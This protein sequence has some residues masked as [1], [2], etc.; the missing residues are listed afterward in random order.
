MA[1]E[2][3]KTPASGTADHR[4]RSCW[5]LRRKLA[6][7][8]IESE[9]MV[10]VALSSGI[11]VSAEDIAVVRRARHA[12][13][14]FSGTDDL[15]IALYDTATRLSRL[16]NYPNA[17]V[18]SDLR[19]AD[20]LLSY[21]ARA[22]GP[23]SPSDINA[24][25]QARLAQITRVWSPAIEAAF[26]PA[27]DRVAHSV[28][29]VVAETAGSEARQ[30]ARRAIR[31]YT[32]S[33]VCLTV[34]V[35]GLSCMLFTVNQIS[36]DVA[37]IVALNDAGA[38]AL[39]NQLV[40]HGAN[41]ALAEQKQQR[42]LRTLL[43]STY[44]QHYESKGDA[45]EV[46][47]AR[48]KANNELQALSNS[49]PAL[50]IKDSLQQFAT[51]NR[52][53][54]NEVHRI[55][56]I[57]RLLQVSVTNRYTDRDPDCTDDAMRPMVVAS[58]AAAS[59]PTAGDWICDRKRIRDSL[60]IKV[61]ILQASAPEIEQDNDAVRPETVIDDGFI[62]IAAYQDIRA[63]AVYGRE[64]ILSFVGALT[65][66]VLPVFYSWLGAC[67]A[68]LRKIKVECETSR[69]HPE[70]SKVA[71]RS[72]V[73]CAIIVGIAI[74]LFSDFVQGG[75]NISPLGVAFVAGYASDKFFYFIDR[76][77]DVIFPTRTM[78][79]S[80][81]PRSDRSGEKAGAAP[82][83]PPRD[84]APGSLEPTQPV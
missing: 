71:N 31:I 21:A 32:W 73:T 59:S 72:H 6:A 48:E 11:E 28:M 25:S 1:E 30:G 10:A 76:L 56:L 51:N 22:A 35:V 36:D 40:S 26:Y 45:P 18:A 57:G 67:A 61:P 79:R 14:H 20:E 33:A 74:G 5:L 19:Q 62:K 60:E 75:K 78:A 58:A 41:I 70:Y 8:V 38:M 66:F 23:V 52:Q 77:V 83:R 42:D 50:Q 44:R 69:F 29:P 24:L 9:K 63:M 34:V 15:E 46:I 43:G 65:G 39:H 64:I 4:R 68:I 47:D 49:Q 2:H 82:Q 7:Q 16:V 17:Q 53:L 12:L 55:R 37:R 3:T 84:S 54:F 13:W 80:E 81:A 27:Y